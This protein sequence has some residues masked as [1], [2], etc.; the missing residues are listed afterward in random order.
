MKAFCCEFSR[1][2]LAT[3]CISAATLCWKN[4]VTTTINLNLGQY[5]TFADMSHITSLSLEEEFRQIEELDGF[6]F[7]QFVGSL[8]S[9]ESK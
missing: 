3:K 4:I 1:N 6:Y 8:H 2:L 9:I 5:L 7:D